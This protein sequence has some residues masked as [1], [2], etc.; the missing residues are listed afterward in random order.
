MAQV[1]CIGGACIDRKYHILSEPQPG[2]SNPSRARRSF[3]GVA[4]NVAENLARLKVDAALF[5]VVGNDENGLALLDHAQHAGVD[6]SLMIRDSN[7]V[8]PEYGA[9]LSP[10]GDLVIGMADMEAID[11]LRPHDIGKHWDTIASSAWLF[12]DCNVGGDVLAWCIAQARSSNIKLAI[13]A[14]SEPKVC[15]LPDDLSGVDL[16][17]LNEKEA[18]VYLYE[19]IGVFRKRTPVERAQSIRACGPAAVLLTRGADGLVAAGERSAEL[20]ALRANCVDETGAG[21]ALIAATMYRLLEGDE[22]M[23]AARVGSLCAGLTVES[24][25]SVR[26]DLTPA[27]LHGQKHRLEACA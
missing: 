22:F 24:P 7:F 2:T 17:I 16:L 26:P 6:V 8:T 18:A 21:D 25:S 10:Q 12:V 27:M 3:G 9:V 20:P 13:D 19:D 14:V 11:A 15:R 23:E 4:R 5:S 1:V